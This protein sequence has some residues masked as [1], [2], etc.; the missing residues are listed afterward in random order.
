MQTPIMPI[1]VTALAAIFFGS[2]MVIIPVAGATARIAL[3]PIVASQRSARESGTRS[4]EIAMLERRM[5]LLEQEVQMLSGIREDV[6]R[7]VE[8]L[9]FQRKLEGRTPPREGRG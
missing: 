1:D 3:K 7:L 9:E 8:D 2:L 6:G 4:E 5:A